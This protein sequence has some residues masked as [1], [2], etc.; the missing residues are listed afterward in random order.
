MKKEKGQKRWRNFED[1]FK[2]S[3]LKMTH[4]GLLQSTPDEV[5][6]D[7]NEVILGLSTLPC[8]LEL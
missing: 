8:S 3:H 6:D 5:T 1:I 2:T 7:C 4:G